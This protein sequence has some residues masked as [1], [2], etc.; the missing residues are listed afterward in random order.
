MYW[1][2]II[3]FQSTRFYII[4]LIH[5]TICKVRMLQKSQVN[6]GYLVKCEKCSRD[7]FSKLKQKKSGLDK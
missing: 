3:S 5:N 4:E 7:E 2:E 1:H 6:I